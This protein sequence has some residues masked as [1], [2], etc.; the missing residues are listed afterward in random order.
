MKLF[1]QNPDIVEY[2]SVTQGVVS[3][4]RPDAQSEGQEPAKGDMRAPRYR[5][6]LSRRNLVGPQQTSLYTHVMPIK[7]CPEQGNREVLVSSVTSRNS[8]LRC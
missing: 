1:H 2:F 4:P 5:V 8:D 7:R 3:S 6:I